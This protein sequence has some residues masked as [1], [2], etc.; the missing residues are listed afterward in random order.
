M[1]A[2]RWSAPQQADNDQNDFWIIAM[3]T[4]T[5]GFLIGLV[6]GVA[7]ALVWMQK[8][9]PPP[10]QLQPTI[11]KEK[12]E[13]PGLA[14]WEQLMKTCQHPKVSKVGSNQYQLK[15]RCLVCGA[16]WATRIVASGLEPLHIE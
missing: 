8:R 3:I 12:V 4:I 9:R 16:R 7:V 14:E 13:P 15:R 11:K 10:L 1:E 6:V 2:V 5:F